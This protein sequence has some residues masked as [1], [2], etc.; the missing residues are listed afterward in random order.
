MVAKFQARPFNMSVDQVYA[1]TSDSTDEQVEQFYADLETTLN[2]IL[3]KDIVIIADD[4]NAKV[5]S[6]NNGWERVMGNFEYGDKNDREERL[7]EF[8]QERDIII[9][10]MK[11]QQKN[12]RKWTWR[13]NDEKQET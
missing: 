3:K 6:D 8:A 4:W 2:D 13:S 5:G 11:F 10:N 12:C 9:C 7:L 1:P